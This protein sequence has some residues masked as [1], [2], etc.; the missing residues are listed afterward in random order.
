MLS[1]KVDSAS[2]LGLR[3]TIDATAV[4]SLDALD[5]ANAAVASHADAKNSAELAKES[6]ALDVVADASYPVSEGTP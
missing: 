2:V 5:A 1:G 3:S 4:A 6:A